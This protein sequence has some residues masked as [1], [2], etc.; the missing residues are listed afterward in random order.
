MLLIVPCGLYAQLGIKAGLNFVNVSNA[1]SLNA[2]SRSGFNAGII[3]GGKSS[4]ILGFRSEL[5]YSKQ[6]YNYKSGTSSGG[7]DLDYVVSS[8]LLCLNITKYVQ[9]QA[10]MQTAF[11]ISANV[12][13][14]SNYGFSN[15]GTSKTASYFNRFDY[16]LGGGIEVHPLSG[17]LVGARMNVSLGNLYGSVESG[18]SPSFAAV[19]MKK[20]VFQV[21]VGWRFGKQSSSSKKQEQE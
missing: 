16:G 14:S 19:D 2:S 12:D 4:G 7:V 11:L 15:G 1:S 8:N 10:G 3:L 20:N 9:L 18:Q 5:T 13:S 6:G 21:F 17:L